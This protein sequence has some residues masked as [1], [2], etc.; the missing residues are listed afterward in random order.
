MGDEDLNLGKQK[1]FKMLWIIIG[2]VLVLL[3]VVIGT[4]YAMGMIRVPETIAGNGQTEAVDEVEK[5]VDAI[6][7]P[8]SSF[9]VNF[10]QGDGTRF[11]QITMTALARSEEVVNAI[12]K[13]EPAIRNNLLLL[14]GGQ[15]PTALRTRQGKEELRKMV[16]KE[17]QTIL[18]K[19]TGNK[20]VE[21]IFFIGFVMQ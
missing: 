18:E 6:Y 15:D 4:L 17:V 5:G 19:R 7:F 12:K 2:S 1:S 11:L 20:G 21:E 13:H 9:T 10:R 14:L 3:L 16:L 8:L